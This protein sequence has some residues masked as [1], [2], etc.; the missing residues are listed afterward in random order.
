MKYALYG[1]GNRWLRMGKQDIPNVSKYYDC[2]YS[3]LE[4]ALEDSK[5]FAERIQIIKI[6]NLDTKEIVYQGKRP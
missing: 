1:L 4:E 5:R 3:S 2:V 6:K